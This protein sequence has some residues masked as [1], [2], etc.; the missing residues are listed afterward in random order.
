MF[1]VAKGKWSDWGE[2]SNCSVFCG[3]SGFQMRNRTCLNSITSFMQEDCATANENSKF[4]I[5]ICNNECSK[6]KLLIEL[7]ILFAIA[8]VKL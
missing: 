6:L 8:F 5:K 1:F 4:E 7:I 3:A 2:W